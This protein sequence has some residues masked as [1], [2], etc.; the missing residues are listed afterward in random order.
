MLGL[1]IF[2]NNG[3]YDFYTIIRRN[4]GEDRSPLT[5]TATSRGATDKFP[6]PGLIYILFIYL[7]SIIKNFKKSREWFVF[8]SELR[9]YL[10]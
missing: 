4:R 8:V 7:I 5:T 1:D 10:Y 2:V 3:P 6:L 9:A